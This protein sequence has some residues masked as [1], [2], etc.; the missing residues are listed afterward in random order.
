MD[1]CKMEHSEKMD[2]NNESLEQREARA[3][4]LQRA[5][6]EDG[7]VEAQTRLGL[8]YLTGRGVQ[9]DDAQAIQW[10]RKA[11]EQGDGKGQHFLGVMYHEGRGAKQDEAQ[12]LHWQVLGG[13]NGD[14]RTWYTRT[15]KIKT[16]A[17]N[18]LNKQ[19][20]SRS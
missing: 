6:A 12:A 16:P 9:Q 20:K 10:F 8:F 7:D 17:I 14:T 13:S 4:E 19:N 3:V 1:S 2:A 11:A 5:L 15:R 18:L